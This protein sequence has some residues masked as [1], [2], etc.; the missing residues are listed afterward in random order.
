MTSYSSPM[1]H[2]VVKA[3]IVCVVAFSVGAVS[4]VGVARAEYRANVWAGIF[5]GNTGI[6]AATACPLPPAMTVSGYGLTNSN[7]YAVFNYLRAYARIWH[8]ESPGPNLLQAHS[9]GSCS[10]CTYATAPCIASSGDTD[11]LA[12]QSVFQDLSG[13]QYVFWYTSVPDYSASCYNYWSAGNSC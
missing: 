10:N 9:T 1:R 13:Q 8:H 6:V 3:L 7:W 11:K 5:A 2:F 4:G 12:N